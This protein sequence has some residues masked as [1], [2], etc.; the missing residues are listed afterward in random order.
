MR[1]PFF[2]AD[3]LVSRV[4]NFCRVL[5]T[6]HSGWWASLGIFLPIELRCR[7]STK[8]DSFFGS[9]A[10]EQRER[11]ARS[12]LF[13]CLRAL[14]VRL[15]LVEQ[16]IEPIGFETLLLLGHPRL[17][18]GRLSD[19]ALGRRTDVSRWQRPLPKASRCVNMRRTAVRRQTIRRW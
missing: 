14:Q 3:G 6:G 16:D 17:L 9:N 12:H 5:Q 1:T 10:F 19:N 8:G 13:G 18:L 4:M 7:R 11:T 15:Q 2:L